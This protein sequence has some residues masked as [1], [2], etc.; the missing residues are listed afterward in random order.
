MI[1]F[2]EFI[3]FMCKAAEPGQESELC[4]FCYS[5]NMKMCFWVIPTDYG[6]IMNTK[7]TPIG[8][9]QIGQSMN[10]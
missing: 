5:L 7:T 6:K 10:L 1:A 9:V 2:Y 8:F 3:T 4:Y